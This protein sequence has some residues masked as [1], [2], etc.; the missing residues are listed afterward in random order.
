MDYRRDYKSFDTVK[1]NFY[2]PQYEHRPF[3]N[4]RPTPRLDYGE[5]HQVY[6]GGSQEREY[7]GHVHGRDGWPR[8]Q[9]HDYRMQRPSAS[10]R[11]E[12]WASGEFG[13][14]QSKAD[15]DYEG[16][17]R[18]LV[19]TS[20]GYYGDR[21]A[22]QQGWGDLIIGRGHARYPS[23]QEGGVIPDWFTPPREGSYGR[24]P[25][26][27]SVVPYVGE[28]ID[29][30]DGEGLFSPPYS[31]RVN[32]YIRDSEDPGYGRIADRQQHCSSV[33]T[34]DDARLAAL[35]IKLQPAKGDLGSSRIDTPGAF[36]DRSPPRDAAALVHPDRM[37]LLKPEEERDQSIESGELQ[38]KVTG[39]NMVPLPATRMK[40]VRKPEPKATV[41]HGPQPVLTLPSKPHVVA[42]PPF[43]S[44]QSLSAQDGHQWAKRGSA[45]GM[46]GRGRGG[47][48]GGGDARGGG[49]ARGGRGRGNQN[50]GRGRGRGRGTIHSS[51]NVQT[52]GAP[53]PGKR[54]KLEE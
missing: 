40:S 53:Q 33:G 9:N 54:I 35:P 10:F 51:P 50:I 30:A 41:S 15:F 42:P 23:I 26:R 24:S 39:S 28:K 37:Q 46:R 1:R 29:Y 12:P 31:L 25:G 32:S 38:E 21:I 5:A 48:R 3:Q 45:Q 27:P 8:E 4:E 18:I 7:R 34:D 49:G 44:S 36:Q 11:G 20:S 19:E 22:R 16:Y 17:R 2:T 14:Y 43:H 52:Q 47:A 6:Q 13:Q